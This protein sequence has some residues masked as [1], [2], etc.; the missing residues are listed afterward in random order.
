MNVDFF[1]TFDVTAKI[2]ANKERVFPNGHDPVPK[3]KL[4]KAR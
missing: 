1:D 4:D 3:H 2:F